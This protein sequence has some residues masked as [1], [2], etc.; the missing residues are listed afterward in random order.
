MQTYMIL[1]DDNSSIS[2]INQYYEIHQYLKNCIYQ[3]L[4]V[5]TKGEEI[6]Y[7]AYLASQKCDFLVVIGGYKVFYET[8]LGMLKAKKQQKIFD[9]V[10]ILYIPDVLKTA[11][12]RNF[13]YIKSLSLYIQRCLENPT[14]FL[15]VYQ[16]NENI[17]T[18]LALENC[19]NSWVKWLPNTSNSY[20]YLKKLF[21]KYLFFDFVTG[22][23]QF[24]IDGKKIQGEY[25]M[26]LFANFRYLD[27]HKIFPKA[28]LND[29]KLDILL[30]KKISKFYA[31]KELTDY[32]NGKIP[33]DELSFLE[34]YQGNHIEFFS[35]HPEHHSFYLDENR[36]V[37]ESDY[38]Q[39][40]LLDRVKI[41]KGN[42]W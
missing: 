37:K 3:G 30:I 15:D 1:A 33:L 21:Q 10:P 4:Y 12:G 41:F 35:N 27:R 26:S 25:V 40:L 24:V 19:K 17:F 7:Q 34:H 23:R 22:E 36:Y 28:L 6:S 29:G 13:G 16:F 8:I 42:S 5:A 2:E 20:V 39:I 32:L 38:N 18:S 11:L 31:L 14:T 9:S